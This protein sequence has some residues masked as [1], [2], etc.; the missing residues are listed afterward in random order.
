MSNDPRPRPTRVLVSSGQQPIRE[1]FMNS[2]N[3]DDKPVPFESFDSR[4]GTFLK[5]LSRHNKPL[6]QKPPQ[7]VKA[8]QRI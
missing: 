6:E 1:S 5:I 7:L 4:P 3:S 8:I 2:V